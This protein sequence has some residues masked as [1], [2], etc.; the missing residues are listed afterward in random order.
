ME[1]EEKLR[2]VMGAMTLTAIKIDIVLEVIIS[3]S[4]SADRGEDTNDLKTLCEFC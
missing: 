3:S 2:L 1:W 4:S